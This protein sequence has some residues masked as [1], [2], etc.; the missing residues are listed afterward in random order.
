MKPRNYILRVLKNKREV[1]RVQTH[2]IRLFLR[3]LRTIIWQHRGIKVYLRVYYGKH[4]DNFG[5]VSEFHN[6]G[7]Y[8]TK[9]DLWLAFNAFREEE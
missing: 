5:K 6:D 8:E 3:H 7:W 9:P 4:L 1:Q 2:F